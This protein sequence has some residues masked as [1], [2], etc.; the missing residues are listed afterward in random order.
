MATGSLSSG[1]LSA[2]GSGQQGVE[3]IVCAGVIF[4]VVHMAV[5]D[6]GAG[7]CS[8]VYKHR[9]VTG[10]VSGL[11]WR[12]VLRGENVTVNSGVER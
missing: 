9:A 4:S 8:L 12:R 2:V 11:T 3:T 5:V 10:V 6:A 1:G 7:E